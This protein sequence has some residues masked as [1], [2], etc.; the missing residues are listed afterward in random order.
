[1]TC[2][3]VRSSLAAAILLCCAPSAFAQALPIALDESVT[4]EITN[5][6]QVDAWAFDVPRPAAAAYD[7][8]EGHTPCDGPAAVAVLVGSGMTEEEGLRALAL[9]VRE[10]LVTVAAGVVSVVEGAR[11]WF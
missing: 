4:G 1:M 8:L 11:R 10:E 3:A 9:A 6:L 2:H 5:A 7:A